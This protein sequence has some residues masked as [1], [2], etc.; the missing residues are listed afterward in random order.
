MP[1]RTLTPFLPSDWSDSGSGSTAESWFY[2]IFIDINDTT[3]SVVST[4]LS[5]AQFHRGMKGLNQSR[6]CTLPC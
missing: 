1:K 2:R 6:G 4:S 5:Q 3:Y